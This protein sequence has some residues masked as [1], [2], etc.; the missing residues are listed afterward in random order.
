[1]VFYHADMGYLNVR[2]MLIRMLTWILTDFLTFFFSVMTHVLTDS[3]VCCHSGFL[4]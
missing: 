4:V 3:T 1:M 2:Q